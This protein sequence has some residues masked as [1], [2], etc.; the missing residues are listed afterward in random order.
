MSDPH[1]YPVELRHAHK[2]LDN[3][4]KNYPV[5]PGDTVSH[6][7]ARACAD[8]GWAVRQADGR[9]IPTAKGLTAHFKDDP[10]AWR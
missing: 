3:I 4:V 8:M 10:G 2:E 7:T 9:W 1:H 6:P 5:C